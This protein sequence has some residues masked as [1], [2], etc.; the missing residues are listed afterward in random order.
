MRGVKR[1]FKKILKMCVEAKREI[2]FL[3]VSKFKQEKF[4]RQG[5][6][7]SRFYW[8]EAVQYFSKTINR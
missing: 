3:I 8:H 4:A 6:N 1:G 2:C 7:A 5:Y